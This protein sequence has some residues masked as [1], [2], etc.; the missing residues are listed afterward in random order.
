MRCLGLHE[1]GA[2]CV[3]DAFGGDEVGV[4]FEL[5]PGVGAGPHAGEGARGAGVGGACGLAELGGL[6]VEGLGPE[7]ECELIDVGFAFG[8]VAGLELGGPVSVVVAEDHERGVGDVVAQQRRRSAQQ[9]V[10]D[11]E[12]AVQE[13]EWAFGVEGFQPQRDLGDLDGQVVE[14]DAVDAAF[15]HVGGGGA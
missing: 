3:G 15:D 2:P 10:A 9:R 6:D 11:P 1:R 7:I 8:L 14:V 13:R 5:A 12:V 4:G